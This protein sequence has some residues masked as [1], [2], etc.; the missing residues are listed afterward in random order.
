MYLGVITLVVIVLAMFAGS[1][2]GLL[3]FRNLTKKIR[4]HSQEYPLVAELGQQ[5]SELRSELWQ[6]SQASGQSESNPYRHAFAKLTVRSKLVTVEKTLNQ[7]RLMLAE[8]DFANRQVGTRDDAIDLVEEF[9]DGLERISNLIQEPIWGEDITP[10]SRL[11]DPVEN[12]LANLQNLVTNLPSFMQAR[13]EDFSRKARAEF[14]TLVMFS[15]LLGAIAGMTLCY[16]IWG[17]R[18]RIAQPLEAL[19]AGSREVAAGNYDYRIELKRQD[20]IAELA[21]AFNEMTGNFQKINLDLNQKVQQRTK[22]VV[23]SE[24]MAS[25]G[26]LAAGVAHEINNPLAT[27]A[28]SAESLEMRLIDLLQEVGVPVHEQAA[29]DVAEMLK[30]LR[31]IQDEAFRCKGITAGLLDFSRMGDVK[32]IATPL[33]EVIETVIDMVKPLSKYRDRNIHFSATPGIEC[34]CNAQEMKQVVLNLITNALGSVEPGGKVEIQLQPAGD[35]AVLQVKDD[36]CGMTDEVL[37][38]LFEPFFTRRRD[39]Q[40]TGLGLSIT[41]QIIAEHGGQIRASSAGPGLGSVFTVQLPL[42]KNDQSKNVK[43]AA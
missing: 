37:Q 36:G 15:V 3:K 10:Q 28:W 26:F 8:S 7:Y 20:E 11:F 35:H 29:P 43:V 40:G 4:E 17:F 24:K 39:G 42:A 14:L 25:V 27:I 6:L 30:Y 23:Q 1:M 5:V 33:A 22:E 34:I 9:Y 31:R 41:Y 13:M 12:E 18:N 19:I 38:H 2:H 16:L 32:K 21:S